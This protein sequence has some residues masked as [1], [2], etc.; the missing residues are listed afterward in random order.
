MLLILR[1]FSTCI[2][3]GFSP[4][5]YLFGKFMVRFPEVWMAYRLPTSINS[6]E[7]CLNM[8]T[9]SSSTTKVTGCAAAMP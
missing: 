1:L 3:F 7:Y 8:E 6:L 5:A 2:L 9:L 4:Y